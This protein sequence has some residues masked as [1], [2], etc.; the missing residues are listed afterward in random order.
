[1]EIVGS[2]GRSLTAAWSAGAEAHLGVTVAGF[3]NF[4]LMYGPNTNLG[5]NSI[6][7]MIECQTAYIL[8]C[9]RKLREGRVRSIEVRPD[10]MGRFNDALQNEIRQSVWAAGCRSWYKT[11]DGKVTNNW[12]GFTTEY[13]WRTREPDFT[14]FRMVPAR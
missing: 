12:S 11:D 7:F 10:A 6:I 9:L 4:F 13:W 8:G 3:P 14:D 5:H 1:M 2:G